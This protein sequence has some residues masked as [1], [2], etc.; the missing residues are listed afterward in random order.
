MITC[1]WSQ[2]VR[3]IPSRSPVASKGDDD[4]EQKERAE[5]LARH[6][7]EADP[8]KKC[9][10]PSLNCHTLL[11]ATNGQCHEMKKND[12]SHE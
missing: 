12:E 2:Y 1:T 9:E 4:E 6:G 11:G 8:A 5:G 3:K 10:M 7:D